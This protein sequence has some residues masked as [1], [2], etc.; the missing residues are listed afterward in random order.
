MGVPLAFPLGIL[1]GLLEFVPVVGPLLAAIPGV[2]VAFAQAA[3]N[4]ML[5]GKQLNKWANE[6]KQRDNLP[7]RIVLWNG[8]KYD[9]GDFYEAEGHGIHYNTACVDAPCFSYS[10]L[11][12]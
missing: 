4:G 3:E 12:G 9:F 5:I 8:K 10:R 7:A 1:S 6:V 11:F 2:L